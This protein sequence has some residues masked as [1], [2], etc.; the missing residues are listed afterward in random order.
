MER[1]L[2]L[3]NRDLL[4]YQAGLFFVSHRL[5]QSGKY[6]GGDT[7]HHIRKDIL[8]NPFKRPGPS[9]LAVTLGRQ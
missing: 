3:E 4:Q 1:L 6:P 7:Y 9:H 2:Y 5:L 8:K